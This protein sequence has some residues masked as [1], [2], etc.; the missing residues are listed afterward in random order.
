MEKE[1]TIEGLVDGVICFDYLPC[2][3]YAMCHNGVSVCC[4][5]TIRNNGAADWRNVKIS[6]SGEIIKYS[7]EVIDRLPSTQVVRVDKIAIIPEMP[8]LLAL[9]E[10]IHSE[11]TLLVCEEKAEIFRKSFPIELMAFDQWTGLGIMPELLASFVTPNHPFLSRVSVK[12][13]QFLEKWTG[14]SALDGYQTQN[15]NRVRQQVAAIYEAL[16]SE[17]LVYSTAPVSFEEYGQRIRLV[18]RVLTGKQANC[19]D[20]TLLYAS[21][22]ESIGIHPI[23]ILLKNHAFLGVWL[24]DDMYTQSVGD[25]ASFLLKGCSDGINDIVLVESTFLASSDAVPFEDAVLSARNTLL[26]KEEEFAMF[27]DVRHCRLGKIRPLPLP[28]LNDGAWQMENE[29]VSHANATENIMQLNRF[30]LKLEDNNVPVTKQII[31][32]RKLLDFSLRNNLLNMRIGRKVIPFVSFSIDHLEDNLQSGENFQLLPLPGNEPLEPEEIGIYN[33]AFYATQLEDLV[34]QGLRN[35]K[36]Y[37]YLSRKDLDDGLK[38]LYRESRTALEENGAN[39]LFLVLGVLKWYESAKSERARFA[40]LLL[41]PVELVRRGGP[42]GYVIRARDEE[43]IL[44][45]TLV[46]LLKQEYKIEL[47]GVSPLPV[48]ESGVDVKKIFAIVRTFI[49]HLK[50]WDVLEESMLGLFSF[51]KFVMWNDIHTHADKL[52]EHPILASLMENRLMLSNDRPNVDAREV[53][54]S[55][56]PSDFAIPVDVDSSQMEAVIEAGEGKS[57][58][59]YGPPGTG[60]SQT[61]TNMIANALYKGKR[62]LFVAEKMAALSVV[63]ERLS[64]IG[65]EPFCLEL[66]S[67]KV[68]KSHFL[69][70]MEKALNVVHIQSPADYEETSHKLLEKRK[71]LIGYMEALHRPHASGISLYDCI[72]RYIAIESEEL[73]V[74]LELLS[75]ISEERISHYMEQLRELDTVF[76]ITGH[77]AKHPLRGLLLKDSTEEG[78]KRLVQLL[79]GIR[80]SLE[81]WNG[82]R[83]YAASLWNVTLSDSAE[84]L[85]IMGGLSEQLRA[86]PLLNA[87]L[88]DDFGRPERWEELRTVCEAGVRRD[89]IAAV[90]LQTCSPRILE[91]DPFMLR[92]NWVAVQEKWFL[93]RFF[94]KRAYMKKMRMFVPALQEENISTLLDQL[95][96]YD[97]Y[98]KCVSDERGELSRLFGHWALPD[99]ENWE[100]IS[101]VLNRMPLLWNG[102]QR[103]AEVSGT[104]IR[105]LRSSLLAQAGSEWSLFLMTNELPLVQMSECAVAIQDFSAQMDGL[106]EMEQPE[107]NYTCTLLAW[108]DRWLDNLELSNDWLL[109]CKRRDTLVAEGLGTAVNAIVAQHK[110]GTEVA[111]AFLKGLY[112]RL[113]MRAVESDESLRLFNGLLF[114]KMIDKYK[115]LTRTFQDLSKKELYC[116]LA[117]RIPSMIM[118]ASANSEV[119]ILKRNIANGGRGTSIR[120]IIDQI[121]TL[122]SKLCPCMLMSPISVAQYVDMDEEKFDLVIFDEASQM[123]TNEAVGSIARGKALVVVGDPK[124]MPPTSFFSSNQV[125]EEEADL[126]DMESILDDCISLSIPSRYLTWHYRS[127]H[128]SLIAF[129][130]SQYYDGKLYTFPSV[131]DRASKISL[132]PVSGTYDKGRTRCNRAEAKAIV[133]EVIRRLSDP[134]LSQRS[135]GIIS[136]SKVQ[137]NLIEDLLTEELARNPKLEEKAYQSVEPI[138]IKNLE[139]VQGDERDVILFSIGYGPDKYG[140]VSMNFGPLNNKGGERR[141]NVA[142]S[143]ARYEMIV[144]ST[145]TA[146]QIDLRRTQSVG[147]AG[148]KNFLQFAESGMSPVA[149]SQ[150]QTVEDSCMVH[151]IAEALTALGYKVDAQVGR[152]S[153]KVDLAVVDSRNPNR[154]VLGILCDGKNYYETKTTRDREIVQPGV[155]QMLNWNIERVWSVDWFMHRD[156]VVERLAGRLKKLS[157]QC[158]TAPLP[159]PSPVVDNR[160]FTLK[161]EKILYVVNDRCLP[162]QMEPFPKASLPGTAYEVLAGRDIVQKQLRAIVAIEQ[163]VTNLWLYKRI[164]QIWGLNRCTPRVQAMIDELLRKMYTDPLVVDGVKTYWLSRNASKGYRTYRIDSDRDIQEIPIRELMN[165]TLDVIDQQVSLPQADLMRAVAQQLGF[166]RK[167]ILADT[168]IGRAV[169]LLLE[170]GELVLHNG[171]VVKAEG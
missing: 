82:C 170:K 156:K 36:M 140:R 158:G 147:V 142:V 70:Q 27:I 30:E 96:T 111:D 49:R 120:K 77:P 104:D 110:N 58:I 32:E 130:N 168:A 106:A 43:I 109:W 1:Y 67:N 144:F 94:A 80:V 139:N 133:R 16:R 83:E 54:R 115:E 44:N 56:S 46:E 171:K 112:H 163:P 15:P 113:A 60:K 118:E 65:L 24:T 89:E 69:K 116:R 119:G 121:P 5:L 105:I 141:L 167:R 160:T 18:D 47:K 50:G 8:R 166:V 71:Q 57:F 146:D 26:K 45:V 74:D 125:N 4:G 135:I 13:S 21:C 28:V 72:S 153:F 129:S 3:N 40:P 17:A 84:L 93:P 22:L 68:T 31:W 86:M 23:L 151:Q 108:L 92:R 114:E 101:V 107:R 154:Y 124:Q 100:K 95:E 102:M 81:K 145:L 148:L 155:L 61:I 55:F 35:K 88:F 99:K 25:D 42:W 132:V 37:A 62:V 34:L 159:I 7:C 66:H 149:V 122:L 10:G 150:I 12:G 126:D 157:R 103:L 136:F 59:L 6:I 76:Q 85:Q 9:T 165:A 20:L 90:I 91:E 143:R 19:L 53:D 138:F 169:Q 51:N 134:Q 78:R 79:S 73:Q 162:Y 152:S 131:D 164:N 38:F 11:F 48:D 41:L 123:P 63:K 128:E 29:G 137:Q 14:S 64:R 87:A 161:N 2:V 117:S 98:R 33:S 75:P 127:K 97:R 39:T 52:R